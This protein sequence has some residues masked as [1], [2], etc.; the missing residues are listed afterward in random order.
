MVVKE[1][2]YAINFYQSK[3]GIKVAEKNF[4]LAGKEYNEIAFVYDLTD[5]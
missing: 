4:E 2:K 3:G 5:K 1:N